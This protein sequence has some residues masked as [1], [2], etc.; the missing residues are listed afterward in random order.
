M[1]F[2][3]HSNTQERKSRCLKNCSKFKLRN[4]IS[5]VNHVMILNALNL[6]IMKNFRQN[7]IELTNTN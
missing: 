7:Q 3:L 1:I 5:Q 4:I 2:W 6:K